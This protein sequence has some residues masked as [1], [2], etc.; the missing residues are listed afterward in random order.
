MALAV[1]GK[2]MNLLRLRSLAD[3]K[4]SRARLIFAEK[5]C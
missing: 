4:G 5:N 3:F 2:K 1:G